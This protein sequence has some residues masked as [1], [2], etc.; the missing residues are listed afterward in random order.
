MVMETFHLRH[1]IGEYTPNVTI[2]LRCADSGNLFSDVKCNG[3]CY[4]CDQSKCNIKFNGSISCSI[5]QKKEID[6]YVDCRIIELSHRLYMNEVFEIYARDI[7]EIL[8]KLRDLREVWLRK[9]MDNEDME[10]ISS[11]HNK[12]SKLNS[13]FM[14]SRN[15]PN[16][17]YLE[18]LCDSYKI[19]LKSEVHEFYEKLKE[20]YKVKM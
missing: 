9:D 13:Y 18:D 1:I 7:R 12:L 20:K 3:I 4:K 5:K 14:S 2:A 10:T 11:L 6:E 17:S 8:Y 16:N 15:H 19:E